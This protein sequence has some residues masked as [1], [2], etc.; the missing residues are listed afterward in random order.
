LNQSDHQWECPDGHCL[1]CRAVDH[2]VAC[3]AI[4][5]AAAGNLHRRTA[6]SRPPTEL[7]CP[8]QARSALTVGAVESLSFPKLY[9]PSSRGPTAYDQPK[10]N[11]VAPGGGVLSTVPAIPGE[12]RDS[13]L[14]KRESGTSVASAVVA[15][16]VA[17]LIEKRQREGK[18][19]TPE[20]IHEELLSR[21]VRRL[22]GQPP[23][24]VGGLDLSALSQGW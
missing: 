5:V 19:W 14:F 11:L 22:A 24:A 8:A 17:L 7:L 13:A 12:Q 2:A 20:E 4:V 18:A 6:E 3:G 9:N 15:G 10:P 23:E 21:Y 16:A 1:L